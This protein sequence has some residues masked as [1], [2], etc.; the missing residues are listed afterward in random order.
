[1][2]E[3]VKEDDDGENK[4]KGNRIADENMAQRIET[5]KKKLR[6]RNPLAQGPKAPS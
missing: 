2:A 4:Q 6:H 3:L 1:V 5:M